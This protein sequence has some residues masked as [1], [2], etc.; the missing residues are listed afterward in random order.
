MLTNEIRKLFLEYF[1]GNAHRVVPSSP[2]VPANDDT[3][4]FTNAGMVQFKQYFLGGEQAEFTRAT[5]S[6]CCI[7]AGGKHNDLE[8]VGYTSRHH[9]F[10][11]ML[12]NFSFGDYFKVEAIKFAW[13]FITE[14]LK[15]PPEKL[16]ITVYKDDSEAAKIWLDEIGIDE[17][18][19]SYCAEKD[20]FWSMG[21]VGPCGPCTEIFYDHGPEVAGGPPGSPDEDGDRYVEIWNLV[22]MEFERKEDGKLIPLPMQSVDTGM[23]LER[24]AA[25]MQGVHDN[26]EIDLFQSMITRFQKILPIKMAN[27]V[28]L[29]VIADHMR[30]MV[31]LIAEGIVPSNEGRGYVLRRIVRRAVRYGSKLGLEKKFLYQLV[32]VVIQVMG[33]HYTHLRDKQNLIENAIK[34]EEVQFSKTLHTGLKILEKDLQMLTSQVIPGELVFKMYDTYGFPVD[35][36]QDMAKELSLTLD[37][38]GYEACMAKQQKMAREARKFGTNASTVSIDEQ[39]ISEFTGYQEILN[40]AKVVFITKDNKPLAE[41]STGEEIGIVLTQ[42]PFYAESGGQVG[43]SGTIHGNDFEIIVQDTQKVKNAIVHYGKLIRGTVKLGAEVTATIDEDKRLSI[44]NNHTATHLLHSALKKVLGSHAEQKGSVVREDKLRFDFVHQQPLTQQEIVEIERLVN[45]KI[46][47]NV[48]LQ[49]EEKPL[50]EAIASGAIALFDQ[51]YADKVRVISIDDFSIEL[52]G[53]TH[54][55][56]TGDIGLFKITA[57]YS[58]ATGIRR[59]EAV[60]GSEVLELMQENFAQ[61]TEISK[62]L[63]TNSMNIIEKI[64]LLHQENKK[65]KKDIAA[66]ST[67]KAGSLVDN[68]LS[69]SMM[70]Q[71]KTVIIGQ[72]D[73]LNGKEVKQLVDDLLNKKSDV[74]VVIST[75]EE[76]INA[77]CKIAKDLVKIIQ[78]AEVIKIIC[79]KG[80]GRPDMAQ[81]GT[82]LPSDLKDRIEKASNYIQTNLTS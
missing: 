28:A 55:N 33:E 48:D 79:G 49:V 65:L 43:D 50:Q 59:I 72:V 61:L 1:A 36:M 38:Q 30:S 9:T 60:T 5:S 2:I 4:L 70:F 34:A 35:V 16:W 6:Q 44:K 22:F 63:N 45:N 32:D 39:I 53:G 71:D 69:K 47:E 78:P 80:G 25:V 57:E 13:Q 67:L 51:K 42:T 76:K 27:E 21:P 10:F 18:R 46:R 73:G 23:G 75:I 11:E 82:V 74:V 20:N 56:R 14:E 7:R 62:V 12:G 17:N 54:V 8:N 64:S 40:Q 58:I 24:I 41:V 29:K 81:G 3:L 77:V 31:F 37:I 66:L 19:L 68:L 26:Y 52:C 15:L